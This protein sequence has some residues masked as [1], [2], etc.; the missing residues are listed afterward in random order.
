MQLAITLPLM[1]APAALPMGTANIT[2]SQDHLVIAAGGSVTLTYTIAGA[3]SASL[4]TPSG[5]VS[6][7]AD[8]GQ[9]TYV[10]TPSPSIS[11][12]FPIRAVDAAGGAVVQPLSVI[13]Q[14]SLP[15]LD[16]NA[17]PTRTTVQSGALDSAATWGG[18][19]PGRDDTCLI[20]AGHS[21]TYTGKGFW[22]GRLLIDGALTITGGV[23]IVT[24]LHVRPSG[25]LTRDGT[26]AAG[27]ALVVMM[28]RPKHTNDTADFW[29]VAYIEGK[30]IDRGN[31]V[32]PF[33]RLAR[34]PHAGDTS[35]LL[36]SPVQGWG[37]GN[38]III[39]DSRHLNWNERPGV[40]GAAGNYVSRTEIAV[41]R[42]V[43]ADGLTVY[44]LNPLAWAHPGGYDAAGVLN[45]LPHVGNL[46]RST[47]FVSS[48]PT[49]TAT[50]PHVWVEDH[51][52]LDCYGSVFHGLGRT[53]LNPVQGPTNPA[54]RHNL[55]LK[56]L[57]GPATPL[58]YTHE[59]LPNGCQWR[60]ENCV[61]LEPFPVVTTGAL[62]GLTLS[63]THY[64]LCR[65]NIF[66]N[67]TGSGFA[68]IAGNESCNVIEGNWAIHI[69]GTGGR[70]DNG[71]DG[72][73]FWFRSHNN[74]IRN[75]VAS[76]VI[77]QPYSYGFTIYLYGLG[78]QHIPAYQGADPA[79][80]GQFTTV[81]MNAAPIL[82]FANNE[83]YGALTSGLTYWWVGATGQTPTAGA[84]PSLI[85][86]FVTWNN[87][88]YVLFGYHSSQ[89]TI[90]GLIVRGSEAIMVS[91]NGAKGLYFA[92]YLQDR[93]VLKN[94][95]IQSQRIAFGPTAYMGAVG[96]IVQDSY[97]RNAV[98]VSVGEMWSSSANALVVPPRNWSLH[99]CIFVAPPGMPLVAVQMTA[100]I[101][102]TATANPVQVDQTFVYDFQG[103][104]GDNFQ[105]FRNEQVASAITP[106]TQ[107]VGGFVHLNGS[108]DLNK[109]NAQNWIDHN[110]A[111]GGEVAPSNAT[112]RAGIT[113]LVK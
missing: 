113:G 52:T 84:Q 94:A 87:W 51:A 9:H 22:T 74:W 1:I 54:L 89:L 59:K 105:V 15:A 43:S 76:C 26:T 35:L 107:V 103:V 112:T 45:Y 17:A 100:P 101:I 39:P 91:G 99:N 2:V 69:N 24:D 110:I 88:Q 72:A 36:A 65:G 48:D 78:N 27:K 63:N 44:L 71:R 104:V 92:D 7:V 58:P 90:D 14:Q 80:A 13:V 75:N 83:A 25:T 57:I 23:P 29:R 67:W 46:I 86:N 32:T 66:Y 97:F 81:N 38:K 20:A 11:G 53:T 85:S 34:E 64:G 95:N 5:P 28:N 19:L 6:L 47:G 56:D 70:Q 37:V 4:L 111:I 96:Q 93:F 62:W 42:G 12:P 41:V 16:P 33:V 40:N 109:S 82:E 10:Y 21:L 61:F 77:S 108:P 98:N 30:L 60:L 79:I 18:T 8:G 106:Q 31:T 50:R 73:G 49:V 55:L 102:D 68:T 3:V